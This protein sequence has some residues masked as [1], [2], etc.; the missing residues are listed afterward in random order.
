M[1]EK[2]KQDFKNHQS[3]TFHKEEFIK[4]LPFP[5]ESKHEIGR[6]II[7]DI[8]AAKNSDDMEFCLFFLWVIEED[9]DMLDLLHQI[10][11]EPWHRKYD[12]IIHNLQW[13]EHP[14]SVP[15][16]KIAIQ[17]K[18]DFLEAYSTGTGQFINQCGHALKSI[19]TKEAIDTI[20]DLAENSE[21]P[22]IKIEM[23]YRL[24]KIFPTENTENEDLPRWYDFD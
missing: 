2:L 21:D 23:I 12:D 7:K 16:I 5:I 11:L 13:R 17:Q 24:S 22:I 18:Y 20:K 4:K 3:N 10:L 14:S 8:I 1:I 6:K 9:N 15:V 19:G